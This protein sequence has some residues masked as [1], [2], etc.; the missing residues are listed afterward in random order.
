[1]NA[2]TYIVCFQSDTPHLR[3]EVR[4]KT[5]VFLSR[6]RYFST[7]ILKLMV[8]ITS[9][10][11]SYRFLRIAWGDILSLSDHFPVSRNLYIPRDLVE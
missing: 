1:M 11:G 7:V 5:D 3:L 6:C 10:F 2:R 9:I 8:K 4:R